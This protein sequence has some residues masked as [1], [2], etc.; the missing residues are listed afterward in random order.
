MDWASHGLYT[1]AGPQ[2]LVN[3]SQTASA[4]YCVFVKYFFPAPDFTVT[5]TNTFASTGNEVVSFSPPDQVY[6]LTNTNTIPLHWSAATSASWLDISATNGILAAFDST[7][8]TVYINSTANSLDV[9]DYMDAIAFRN[10]ATD[11][12][13]TRIVNLTVLWP[14]PVADFTGSPTNGMASLPVTFTDTSTGNITSRFWDFGD[15]A[16]TT[17]TTNIVVHTYTPATYDVS[18][19]DVML[20]V[21]GPGGITTNIRPNYITVL[22]AFQPWQIQ[23]FGTTNNPA[24]ASS[25]DPDGD[26]QNNLGEFLSGSDPTNSASAFRITSIMSQGTN[27]AITWTTAGGKTNVVQGGVGD[28]DNNNPAY[29]NLFF[30]MSDSIVIPGNEDVVTNFFDDGSFWGDFSNWPTHY[31][32][33]RLVP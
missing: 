15:G 14:P 27:T 25:A 28:L 4:Q 10:T 24:A 16:T 1:N 20:V 18:T 17:I 32:R 23:Y 19:Y 12:S 21:S 6:A 29:S 3:D 26:G 5:P 13:L 30:D 33:I 2:N 11:A 31:Y 8:I 22:T 9:G 7:N